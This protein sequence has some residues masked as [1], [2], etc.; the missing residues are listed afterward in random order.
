MRAWILFFGVVM[1]TNSY[2]YESVFYCTYQS[3]ECVESNDPIS[4]DKS[5]MIELIERVGAMEKNFI[6]FIDKNGTTIQFYVDAI[7][8]IWVE[9]PTPSE[10]GSY[11][12]QINASEMLAIVKELKEPY[13]NYKEK[14]R[15][16][17]RSW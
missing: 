11:G 13:V 15:L 14:L 3:E 12:K 16:E 5:S 10:Q 7:N 4:I 6:G 17:F 1:A 2:A 9:I 8:E